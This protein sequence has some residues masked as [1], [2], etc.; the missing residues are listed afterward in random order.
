MRENKSRKP[1]RYKMTA[2]EQKILNDKVAEIAKLLAMGKSQKQ[3]RV[4]LSEKYNCTEQVIHIQIKQ[5][6][7]A[8]QSSIEKRLDY[9]IALQRER[10]EN[11]LYGAVE[12]KDF[13]T[14]Q[15][16]IDTMNR[17]YGLYTD[18]KEIKIKENVIKFDFG[19]SPQVGDAEEDDDK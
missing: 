12:K 6:I 11:I 13:A 5:A 14:A 9:V 4:E 1:G 2:A 16:I 15:K 17:L 19:N 3:I 18:K 8:M 7:K 10:L